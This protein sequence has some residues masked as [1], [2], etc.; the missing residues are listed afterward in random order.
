MGIGKIV[1]A[2]NHF[3]PLKNSQEDEKVPEEAFLVLGGMIFPIESKVFT[4]GRNLDNNLV[5]NDPTV[6]R[7][8]A[9]IRYIDSQFLLVD[10]NSSSGTFLN[11]KKISIGQL[12]A[13]DIIQISHTPIMFMYKGASL[14]DGSQKHTRNLKNFD[15][16]NLTNQNDL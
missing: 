14:M 6:S 5:L 16:N 12:F 13:G 11:N 15:E 10:I 3:D 1:S 7:F 2:E 8:H 9:E 4:I